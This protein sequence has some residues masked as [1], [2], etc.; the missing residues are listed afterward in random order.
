MTKGGSRQEKARPK[1]SQ[2]CRL[3]T[4]LL[5][6]SQLF[7]LTHLSGL[8]TPNPMTPLQ[9]LESARGGEGTWHARCR[10]V[11]PAGRSHAQGVSVPEMVWG[12]L[13]AEEGRAAGGSSLQG[14]GVGEMGRATLIIQTNP[15]SAAK[16]KGKGLK[17][18]SG[19]LKYPPI[20][21]C[22]TESPGKS[23]V[24]HPSSWGIS[25]ARSGPARQAGNGAEQGRM[26]AFVCAML[27][28][29]TVGLWL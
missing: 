22:R 3:L 17:L 16:S 4:H 21:A 8:R 23:A 19:I 27:G 5:H 14:V 12:C 26:C 15:E 2:V 29:R 20:V 13:S 24:V 28:L 7:H 9:P 25:L 18:F 11:L 1:H 10:R 6:I